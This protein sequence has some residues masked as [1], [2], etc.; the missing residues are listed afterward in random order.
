LLLLLFPEGK[1]ALSQLSE[2]GF[3][4]GFDLYKCVRKKLNSSQC[5]SSLRR[6]GEKGSAQVLRWEERVL[7]GRRRKNLWEKVASAT[8]KKGGAPTGYTEKAKRILGGGVPSTII[9]HALGEATCTGTTWKGETGLFIA[10]A[11]IAI[12]EKERGGQRCVRQPPRVK[13]KNL[14]QMAWRVHARKTTT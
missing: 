1:Q 11:I 13:E 4:P 9:C 5:P 3:L 14:K 7:A 10:N 8:E 6:G 2:T 12:K